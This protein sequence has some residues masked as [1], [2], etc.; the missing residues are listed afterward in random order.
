ML[1]NSTQDIEVSF[2]VMVYSTTDQHWWQPEVP[3]Q[4]N[5]I[6]NTGLTPSELLDMW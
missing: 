3:Q 1:H 6:A 4:Y 5:M 2:D